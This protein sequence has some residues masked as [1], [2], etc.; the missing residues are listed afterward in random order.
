[1]TDSPITPLV[2]DNGWWSDRRLFERSGRVYYDAKNRDGRTGRVMLYPLG[3]TPHS[4]PVSERTGSPGFAR[5]LR[6][7]FYGEQYYA[8]TEPLDELELERGLP[9]SRAVA[10]LAP[11]IATLVAAE[12]H[13]FF[14]RRLSP[15]DLAFA[16]GDRIVIADDVFVHA[17]VAEGA[18]HVRALPSLAFALLTGTWPLPMAPT[19]ATHLPP[20]FESWMERCLADERSVSNAFHALCD[21]LGVPSPSLDPTGTGVITYRAFGPTTVLEWDAAPGDHVISDSGLL[22]L[23]S[24]GIPRVTDMSGDSGTVRWLTPVGSRLNPGEPLAVIALSGAPQD[25]R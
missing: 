7:G 8:V 5:I 12:N 23:A 24:P 14:W 11:L 6:T 20:A 16:G 10:L 18:S 2:F 13:G 19:T 22:V 17:N 15:S 4:D 9:P 25:E 3:E 21:A 1:M